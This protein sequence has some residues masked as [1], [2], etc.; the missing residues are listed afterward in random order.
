MPRPLFAL[1]AL[2]L[3][4]RTAPLLL[5]SPP[6][7]LPPSQRSTP[8]SLSSSPTTTVARPSSPAARPSSLPSPLSLLPLALHLGTCVLLSS[9]LVSYED[10]D[11]SS[12]KPSPAALT[13]RFNNPAHPSTRGLASS[14][15]ASRLRR[16][17]YD[18]DAAAL[19][20]PSY[21]EA[22]AGYRAT[23][24]PLLR[25]L[26]ARP[27]AAPELASAQAQVAA[28]LRLL[29]PLSA[30]LRSGDVGGARAL[31]LSPPL[32]S[33]LDI[34][35]STLRSAAP[36]LVG[37][38]WNACGWRAGQCGTHADVQEA[39]GE[40]GK[41]LG[42]YDEGEALFCVGVARRALEETLAGIGGA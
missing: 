37:F 27:P 12:N 23:T 4:R 24:L 14:D 32:S 18:G 39:L 6:S 1:L 42:L 15:P 17:A 19:S 3:L 40:L 36:A 22:M 8:T 35:L 30:L 9:L 5:P 13:R 29:S 21:N 28:S 16:F 38:P 7:P 34:A 2:L 20:I 10:Y 25:S 31:L 26:R 33:E 11:C 41:G